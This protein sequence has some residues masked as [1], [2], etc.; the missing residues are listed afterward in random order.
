MNNAWYCQVDGTQTGPYS[1]AELM[2]LAQAGKLRPTDFVRRQQ[3]QQWKPAARVKGLVF[4]ENPIGSRQPTVVSIPPPPPL[5]EFVPFQVVRKLKVRRLPV[6]PLIVGVYGTILLVAFL[7]G[8]PW[9]IVVAGQNSSRPSPPALP[10]ASVPSNRAVAVAPAVP[11]IRVKGADATGEVQQIVSLATG[12]DLYG[13]RFRIVNTGSTAVT[14]SPE[15]LRIHLGDEK[16][17]VTSFDA[18]PFL[19]PATLA[20]GQYVEGLVVYKAQ[21]T[22]GAVART[23]GGGYSYEDSTISVE[24]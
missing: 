15:K 9:A 13:A 17:T 2:Q 12:S 11:R 18:D 6:W 16:L 21:V 8:L 24:Y 5:P 3:S 1:D 23:G 10:A 7:L 22:D 19:R 20:P 4:P 14:V